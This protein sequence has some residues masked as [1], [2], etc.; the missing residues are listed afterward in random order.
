MSNKGWIFSGLVLLLCGC[1]ASPDL[2]QADPPDSPPIN[3]PGDSRSSQSYIVVLKSANVQSKVAQ[4]IA[5]ASG[6]ANTLSANQMRH[7]RERAVTNMIQSLDVSHGISTAQRVFTHALVAGVYQ[8]QAH[9]LAELQSD[10]MI[11]YI[12]K[13]QMYHTSSIQENA[14][15]GLDRIN[16]TQLPLDGLY[17]HTSS[18]EGVHA[19]VIDTGINLLHQEFA[20]RALT[21]VDIVTSGGDAMDCNGHGT[22]VA[23]TIGGTTY[24]VAKKVSLHAVRVLSCSGSGSTS[25]VIAGIEWVTA[26]HIKPAVANMSLGGGASKAIDDAIAASIREGVTYVVAAGNS[27]TSACTSSPARLP[28]AITVGSLTATDSRSSFSN[29]GSCLDIFAPGSDILSS[30]YNSSTASKTISGTSMAAPHVAG[31]VARVLEKEK[32]LMPS[33]VAAKISAGA[34]ADLV[35]DAKT[36]SPNL[37]LNTHFLDSVPPNP[38]TLLIEDLAGARGDQKEFT[39]TLSQPAERLIVQISGGR[40]DADLYLRFGTRPTLRDFDCRPYRYGNAEICT[41]DNP[42]VGVYHLMLRGYLEYSGV[43]LK[44]EQN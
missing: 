6:G 24:G 28:E 25:D 7:L 26:N 10:P 36:G 12:E 22:H 44:V 27:N 21:G 32:N 42:Q 43:Q 5:A 4:A 30:W 2:H 41:L 38:E 13:E 29:Y 14:P 16:Q 18:G 1:G 3:S 23:G 31:V 9:Q 11:A 19:Y 37:I 15:W 17:E 33:E 34:T 40:G 8:L 35:S 20:G 39:Y